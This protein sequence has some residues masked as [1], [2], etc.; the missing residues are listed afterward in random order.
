M[1]LADTDTD[2]SQYPYWNNNNASSKH[3]LG[4]KKAKVNAT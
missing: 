4:F 1:I 2:K 3:F